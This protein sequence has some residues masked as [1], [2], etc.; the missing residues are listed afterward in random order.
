MK[1]Q[2]LPTGVAAVIRNA[3][4]DVLVQDHVKAGAWTIPVGKVEDG[5]TPE[6]GITRELF[7]EMNLKVKSAKII[8]ETI[9][10]L[11]AHGGVNGNVRQVVCEVTVVDI[12]QLKNLEPHKHKE[13]RFMSETDLLKKE[14]TSITKL[15]LEY[16]G[17]KE[18]KV[19][20]GK[21]PENLTLSQEGFAD[22]WAKITKWFKRSFSTEAT[23]LRVASEKVQELLP[24]V[25]ELG[26]YGRD[27]ATLVAD[28]M[29]NNQKTIDAIGRSAFKT[30]ILS[31][32]Y[33]DKPYK[34]Y[35]P[36]AEALQ[37]GQQRVNA[38]VLR[39]LLATE[40]PL[41]KEL[42]RI[43]DFFIHNPTHLHAYLQVSRIAKRI[44][45][46]KAQQSVIRMGLEINNLKAAVAKLP[47]C[48]INLE[49][50]MAPHCTP[51]RH[52][53]A[54]TSPLGLER[55]ILAGDY[56]NL[57]HTFDTS[58]NNGL[59]DSLE[60][61]LSNWQI[62]TYR[63]QDGTSGNLEVVYDLYD[64]EVRRVAD[65]ATRPIRDVYYAVELFMDAGYFGL[66]LH[67]ALAEAQQD[68]LEEVLKELK[69]HPQPITTSLESHSMTDVPANV[70]N[71]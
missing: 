47:Y 49:G 32:T 12:H 34:I 27:I 6:E 8:T 70:P 11:V 24:Q 18:I 16:Q 21:P 71:A 25:R 14:V 26:A 19:K 39:D 54:L 9:E 69:S 44:S 40:T 61:I 38:T 67:R 53:D 65:R 62:R 58:V 31:M 4:G 68:Y 56:V 43:C 13:I 59:Y 64:T 60:T 29:F 15:W 20:T 46:L 52:G 7:E 48:E 23:R 37:V 45:E 30:T 10:H 17:H 28:G 41:K 66:K 35:R 2:A 57:L 33:L 50:L 55:Q 1:D 36:F 5:E 3:R 42:T 51:L 22:F 63:E